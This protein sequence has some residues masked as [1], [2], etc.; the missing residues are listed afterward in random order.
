MR[1]QGILLRRAG[2]TIAP[3]AIERRIDVVRSEAVSIPVSFVFEIRDDRAGFFPREDG[4]LAQGMILPGHGSVPPGIHEFRLADQFLMCSFARRKSDDLVGKTM[5]EV[6]DRIGGLQPL[7]EVGN[8]KGREKI[9]ESAFGEKAE[10]RVMRIEDGWIHVLP[11]DHAFERCHRFTG[12]APFRTSL[13][14]G[15][16][17]VVCFAE[18]FANH[19]D[20]VGFVRHTAPQSASEERSRCLYRTFALHPSNVTPSPALI[21]ALRGRILELVVH[22]MHDASTPERR[23]VA[24]VRFTFFKRVTS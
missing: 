8:Q 3:E 17:R 20:D 9:S 21:S 11:L 24:R 14:E 6:K 23:M 4:E 16:T 1:P 12:F 18:T 10:R 22:G 5:G 19:R 2:G 13:Q 7:F 15:I